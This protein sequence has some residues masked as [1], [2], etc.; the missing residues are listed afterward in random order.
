[1]TQAIDKQ[2]QTKIEAARAIAVAKAPYL[3]RL[4]YT[5]VWREDATPGFDSLAVTLTGILL[6][7][8]AFIEKWSPEQIAGGL[9]HETMHVY[10]EHCRRIGGRDPDEWNKAGD[11]AI[12]PGILQMGLTL[13][14]GLF[15]A[16]IGAPDGLTADEYYDLAQKQK[17]GGKNGKPQPG[18]GQGNQP[19]AGSQPG[20]QPGQQPGVCAGKCGGA[21]TGIRCA[22]DGDADARSPEDIAARVEETRAAMSA[23][24]KAGKLPASWGGLVSDDP[25]PPA[26]IDW[27]KQLSHHVRSAMRTVPG[28]T[29]HRY[30]QPSRKQAGIGYGAGIPVLARYRAVVPSVTVVLDT[31]GSMFSILDECLGEIQGVLTACGGQRIGFMAADAA[32]ASEIQTTSLKEI[33]KNVKG[34]GGTDFCPAIERAAALPRGKR[35]Q[36]LLYVTDL[37]G[38]FPPAPPPG[39]RVVWVAVGE[40]IGAPPPWGSYVRVE[41]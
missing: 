19:G 20:N 21:A 33:I 36:V 25:K 1:M 39:I 26:K 28:A 27:R 40:H 38:R 8:R 37:E 11:R 2:T 23:A 14:Y 16:D 24:K 30:D 32:V 41:P 29:V 5:L 18:K 9:V 3:A 17:Q 10:L 31:S 15:P 22:A 6:W 12:N 4:L 34:G 13:P 35:P 7:S